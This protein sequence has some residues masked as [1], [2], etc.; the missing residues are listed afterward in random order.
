[1]S[2]ACAVCGGEWSC[3]SERICPDC[4]K[5]DASFDDY[6][7]QATV[8]EGADFGA[9]KKPIRITFSFLVR[10]DLPAWHVLVS[11]IFL[12]TMELDK[13]YRPSGSFLQ[14]SWESFG[15][16][17]LR[18]ILAKAVISLMFHRRRYEENLSVPYLL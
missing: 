12:K 7:L 6:R 10:T 15:S 2:W 11:E 3:E 1:M 9:G 4:E 5:I 13:E 14:R 8:A 16:I 18:Y 17:Q